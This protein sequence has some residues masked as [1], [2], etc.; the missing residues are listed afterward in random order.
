M[1]ECSK[2]ELENYPKMAFEQRNIETW[3]KLLVSANRP[4][5]NWALICKN[6]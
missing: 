3:I 6:N 4:L 1:I 2:K 5:N